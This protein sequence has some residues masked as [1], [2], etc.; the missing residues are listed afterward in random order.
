M[1][2]TILAKGAYAQKVAEGIVRW[3]AF[4]ETLMS[5]NPN[6]KSEDLQFEMDPSRNTL[7]AP[8][9]QARVHLVAVLPKASDG[10][11]DM[12]A[13]A[14][15]VRKNL[16][17]LTGTVAGVIYQDIVDANLAG[18]QI[19]ERE[20]RDRHAYTIGTCQGRIQDMRKMG[21]IDTVPIVNVSK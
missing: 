7:R 2:I 21:I 8:A 4:V 5:D 20:I 9:G 12:D 13:V 19:T 1:V 15:T 6:Y 3:L 16:E 17:D 11:F 18:V 10:T 14:I